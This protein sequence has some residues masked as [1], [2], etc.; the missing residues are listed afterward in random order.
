MITHENNFIDRLFQTIEFLRCKVLIPLIPA[1]STSQIMC[2]YSNWITGSKCHITN[3]FQ[4]ATFWTTN[5]CHTDG[6]LKDYY[7]HCEGGSE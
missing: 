6:F 4:L 7:I 5:I 3:W 1:F 2:D